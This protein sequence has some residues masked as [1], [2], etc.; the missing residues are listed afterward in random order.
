MPAPIIKPSNTRFQE[1]IEESL[2]TYIL[3]FE[4]DEDWPV[5]IQVSSIEDSETDLDLDKLKNETIP[6]NGR[7]YIGYIYDKVVP[8]GEVG[9][10]K[11]LPLILVAI[12]IKSTEKQGYKR[13]RR[14]L[15]RIMNEF[16]KIGIYP[17]DFK[18]VKENDKTFQGASRL[19]YISEQY[20]YQFEKYFNAT[21][22][23]N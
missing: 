4:N 5:G 18:A 7:I 1:Q 10:L 19:F 16:Y 21:L 22:W 20:A 8:I 3:N 12:V 9:R 15:Q 14:Y 17:G 2:I 13:I 23:Y 6:H 11:F